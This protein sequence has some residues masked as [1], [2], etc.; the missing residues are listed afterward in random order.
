MSQKNSLFTSIDLKQRAAN[1]HSAK[2]C[3]NSNEKHLTLL[4]EK[5]SNILLIKNHRQATNT[6]LVIK[7][8]LVTDKTIQQSYMNVIIWY[9]KQRI[10]DQYRSCAN[11]S[12]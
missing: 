4:C 2:T 7:V 5:G 12:R 3:F 1:C 10:Q 8:G 9:I 11:D 6:V